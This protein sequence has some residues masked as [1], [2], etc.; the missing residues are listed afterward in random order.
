MQL[1]GIEFVLVIIFDITLHFWHVNIDRNVNIK[2]NLVINCNS[3]WHTIFMDTTI[4]LHW[5]KMIAIYCIRIFNYG[6]N[7]ACHNLQYFIL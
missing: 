4:A 1:L 6:N 7:F 2:D 3:E 5:D